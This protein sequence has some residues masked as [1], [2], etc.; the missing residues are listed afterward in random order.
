MA[1]N[2]IGGDSGSG[3]I[4]VGDNEGTY[5]GTYIGGGTIAYNVE[6]VENF[7]P[8]ANDVGQI[9]MKNYCKYLNLAG[10][11]TSKLPGRNFKHD[12]VVNRETFDT[13]SDNIFNEC[14]KEPEPPTPCTK[15]ILISEKIIY[16][17]GI[18]GIL[19]GAVGTKS[20]PIKKEF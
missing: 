12:L 9:L 16:L 4:G 13:S 17:T 11:K 20:A 2:A 3:I 5:Y 15:M 19:V 7:Q 14:K 1:E 8:N 6:H 10:A 18:L